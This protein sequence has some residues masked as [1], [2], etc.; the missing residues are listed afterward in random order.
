MSLISQTLI[1]QTLQ[2]AQQ[3]CQDKGLQFT[4]KRSEI[5]ELILQSDKPLSAYDIINIYQKQ[6]AKVIASVSVYRILDF[7]I[8]AQLVHKLQ[9]SNKYFVCAHIRCT[10]AHQLSQFLICDRCH[11]VREIDMQP[12]LTKMLKEAVS[13]V[14]FQLIDKA[15]ELHGICFNCQQNE[16]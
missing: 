7:L 12:M 3:H 16:A 4:N 14:D 6:F 10:H 9:S 8:D 1:N 11:Q 2:A 5:L 13:T 15:I